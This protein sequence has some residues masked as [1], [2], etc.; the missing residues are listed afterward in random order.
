MASQSIVLLPKGCV[1]SGFLLLKSQ[2]GGKESLFQMPATG[3]GGGVG[4]WISVQR[5]TPHTG[6]QWGKSFYRQ[7]EGAACRN[8][9]VSSDI[10]LQIGH[11]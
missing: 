8:S 7:K 4:G 2:V 1:G 5:S 6:N 11:W 9:I 10:H 3:G